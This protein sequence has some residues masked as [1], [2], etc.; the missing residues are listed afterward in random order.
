MGLSVITYALAKKYTDATAS[1][2][3][4]LK[5]A[6][7]KV[8]S[9]VK[10]DGQSTITLEWKNDAGAT[11]E[12]EVYIND[13]IMNWK[14][15]TSYIVGDIVFNANDDKI[16]TCITAN[17]DAIFNPNK[18]K[19]IGGGSAECDYYIVNLITDLPNNLTILDRK[20]YFCIEN[21]NF[22]LWNGSNWEVISSSV[23]VVELTQAEY[24][25]LPSA[26]KL[27]GTIYFVKDAGG[28]GGTAVLTNDMIVTKTVGGVNAG[29]QYNAGTLLETILRDILAPVLYPTFTNPSA[30]ISATGSKLLETGST[31]NTTMTITF[32]QGSIH[33]AYGTNGKRAGAATGYVLNGGTPQA[34]NSFSVTVTSAQLTYQGTVNYAEG[35]QPK[36]SAGNDYST[37]LA[38]GSVNSNTIT[39]EF[40]DALYANTSSASVMTKQA[41]VSKNAGSKEL[42]LVATTAANPEQIDVPGSWTVSKIEVLNTLSG[43]WEDATSQ[44]TR[45]TITHDDAAGNPV[46]YNRYTCNLGMSLGARS[47]KISWS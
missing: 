41:L 37:P 47:I 28:S 19:S 11:Q 36:D 1:Q 38:A 4:G 7:C 26:E 14:P 17:E 40:V 16:Y 15:N 44:F 25:A 13:G 5:G 23:K 12:S 20:I 33:P 3:G 46:N 21:G 22:Y 30:S 31:L 29:K 24:D 32:N 27:N 45:T 6:P 39:Y 35:P 34:S 43:K 2:F 9:I 18:W 42:N 8:K 10:I